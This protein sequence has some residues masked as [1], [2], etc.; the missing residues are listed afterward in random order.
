MRKA[1]LARLLARRVDGIFLSD[2]ETGEIGPDLFRHARLMGSKAWSR[3]TARAAITLAG[4]IAG[5]R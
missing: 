2:F 1:N 4:S 3:S 5:S